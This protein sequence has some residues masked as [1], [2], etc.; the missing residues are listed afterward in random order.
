MGGQTMI[1][2]GFIFVVSTATMN[3]LL[4]QKLNWPKSQDFEV[5]YTCELSF[6]VQRPK[7]HF[8][9]SLGASCVVS[10]HQIDPHYYNKQYYSFMQNLNLFNWL[11]SIKR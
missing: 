8:P 7:Q 4:F 9:K 11:K 1:A 2:I 3:I 10:I 6:Q 5:L